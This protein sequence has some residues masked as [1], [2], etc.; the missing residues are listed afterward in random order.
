MENAMEPELLL[1]EPESPVEAEAE[2]PFLPGTN[3]QWAW[4]STSLGLLKTCPQL[5]KYVMID[6]WVSNKESTH[7]RFGSEIHIAMQEYSVC[8]AAEFSHD[9]ALFE[10]VRNLLIRT[11]GWE[12]EEDTRTGKYKNR[13]TL[14]RTVIDVLDFY[15]QEQDDPAKTYIKD[16]GTAAVEL[17]FRFELDFGPSDHPERPYT[18]CGHL[19]RVVTFN[20]EL[21]VVDY[22]TTTTTPGQYFFNQFEPNN[23]MSLYTLASQVILEAPIKGVI[24]EAIQIKLEEPPLTRCVRSF[25]HR[26]AEGLDEWLQDLAYW[27]GLAEH[28]AENNHWPKNDTACGNYG[29]CAFREICSK[30]PTVR[31]RFLQSSFKKRERWNPL[32]T[33]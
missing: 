29:G 13:R 26:T 5:Y 2:S 22:K 11:Y 12:V 15:N 14:L 17:S 23:Q 6:G 30:A 8:R 27:V 20:D 25:T 19:D 9:E 24:I 21:F 18:L 10:V 16:D 32:K 31:D 7:L 3:V 33:R 1:P 28:Y 4:D